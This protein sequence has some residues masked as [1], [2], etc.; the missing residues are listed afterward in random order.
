MVKNKLRFRAYWTLKQS[1]RPSS[2]KVSVQREIY[3]AFSLINV[4]SK[5]VFLWATGQ[6]PKCER[7]LAPCR[8]GWDVKV[9]RGTS[10]HGILMTVVSLLVAD[11]TA[12]G[13]FVIFSPQC[14]PSPLS[15]YSHKKTEQTFFSISSLREFFSAGFCKSRYATFLEIMT[16]ISAVRAVGIFTHTDFTLMLDG[17]PLL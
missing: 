15:F 7:I 11:K 10:A 13:S 16:H 8:Q 9:Q 2:R 12:Y 6:F 5:T 17:C 4:V 14:S 3:N 1:T